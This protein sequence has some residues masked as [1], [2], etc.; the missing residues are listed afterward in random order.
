MNNEK[1]WI[2]FALVL[3]LAGMTAGFALAGDDQEPGSQDGAQAAAEDPQPAPEAAKKADAMRL[4]GAKV[5][6]WNC[7]ACHSE[8]YPRERTDAGW[9]KIVTH[10]RVRANLTSAQAEAVL[11]YL[12]ENN[13]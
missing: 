5:Y 10:M 11:R 2:V 13:E 1:R 9:D 12:K 6:A 4:D 3:L 8:R 7:G